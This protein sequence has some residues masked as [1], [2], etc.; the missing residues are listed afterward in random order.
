MITHATRLPQVAMR[1]LGTPFSF[2]NRKNLRTPIQRNLLLLGGETESSLLIA[3]CIARPLDRFLGACLSFYGWA[4]YFGEMPAGVSDGYWTNVC[5]RCG[6]GVAMERLEFDL[7]LVRRHPFFATYRC[8]VCDTV[9]FFT[10][11]RMY[12]RFSETEGPAW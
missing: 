6:S 5:I 7:K 12:R 10:E 2:L 11:D 1:P 8:P 4:L 3:S 9:N